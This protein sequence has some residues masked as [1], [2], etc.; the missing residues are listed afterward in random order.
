[1]RCETN[2]NPNPGT[3]HSSI[4][5]KIFNLLVSPTVVFEEVAAS[6]PKVVNWLVP[7]ILVCVSSLFLVEVTTG[8]N[9]A[10]AQVQSLVEQGKL[11][12]AQAAVMNTHWP[13]L[14]RLAVC[15]SVVIGT[16]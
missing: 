10:G 11:T 9:G 7:G 15:L 4:A 8:H 12:E 2:N 5:S 13:A 3:A 6:P 14:T 1:M 16:L